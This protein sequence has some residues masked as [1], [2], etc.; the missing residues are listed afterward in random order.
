MRRLGIAATALASIALAAAWL[1]ARPDDV[2]PRPSDAPGSAPPPPA[3]AAG[4]FAAVPSPAVPE[5]AV[6]TA[7]REDAP[8]PD[9]FG[10]LA[11]YEAYPLSDVPHRVVRGWGVGPR[12]PRPGTVG[13][14]VVVDPALGREAL[15]RLV[16]DIRAYHHQADTVAIRILD[17]ME[18]ATYDRH[19][20]GG[21]L[22]AESL[23][24]SVQRNEAL[25]LDV[26]EVLGEPL[27]RRAV[28]DA[29]GGEPSPSGS[30][31]ESGGP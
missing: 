26:A 19:A 14:I 13:A 25:G 5:A 3:D 6:P 21:A 8:L 30:G 4:P 31:G 29:A 18:A 28:E 11:Y 1:V 10:D 15:T 7:D 17:S 23:V 24:G 27:D 2:G 20:D 9:P 22:L 16:E 12:S